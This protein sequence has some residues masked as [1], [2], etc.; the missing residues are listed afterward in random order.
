MYEVSTR[1]RLEGWW[2]KDSIQ[3]LFSSYFVDI[4]NSFDQCFMVESSRRKSIAVCRA[5]QS[6]GNGD[7][8]AEFLLHEVSHFGKVNFVDLD[9]GGQFVGHVIEFLVH[10]LKVVF[11]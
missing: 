11:V 1:K 9:E 6:L 8:G 4:L 3:L 5:N 2:T 7:C 10:S